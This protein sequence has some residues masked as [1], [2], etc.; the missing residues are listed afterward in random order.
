M[1]RRTAALLAAAGIGVMAQAPEVS[2]RILSPQAETYISGP[3]LLRV[4]ID[5][6]PAAARIGRLHIFADG[7][8]VCELQLPPFECEWDSGPMIE[9]HVIRVTAVLADG[10]KLAPQ[11]ARTRKV[12]YAE[13]VDVDVVQVSVVVT[14]GDGRFVQGLRREDFRVFE[15]GVRQ[16]ITH[17]AS[18]D[19][20]LELIAALDVSGSMEDFIPSLQAASTR[21]IQAIP[22][23]NQMT[24]LA[25]NENVFTLVRR[26]SDLAARTK[27][28]E[29]LRSWGGTALYDAIIHSIDALG[30]QPG[31][32]ALIVFSDGEDQSSHATLE[33]AIRRV[34]SSDATVYMIGQGRAAERPALQK[35]MARLASVSGGRA[36]FTQDLERLEAAFHEIIEDL[37]HQYLLSYAPPPGATG[38][39]R[40]IRVEA[41]GGHRVR[42][43]QGYR[44]AKHD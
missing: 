39:W 16:P 22:P 30:R 29:R 18:E 13:R 42:A 36:F 34:E 28:I 10:T 5:P 23:K 21:F 44:L 4:A 3:V 32:R 41:A 8:L 37:S 15:D 33:A 9:E 20:P 19:I 2:L 40:R 14:D 27:A 38:V 12:D 31:R 11:T 1:I 35:L 24:L 43:R 6:P 17:F 7:R 25:F 26:S